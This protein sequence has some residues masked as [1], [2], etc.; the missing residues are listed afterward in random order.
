MDYRI[1]FDLRDGLLCLGFLAG[2]GGAVYLF[3]RNQ[4]TAGG[5]A[6]AAFAMVAALIAA[7]RSRESVSEPAE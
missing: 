2:M 4:K 6:L 7:S 3:S 5:L 1:L